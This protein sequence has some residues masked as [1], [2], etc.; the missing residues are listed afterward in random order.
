MESSRWHNP[1]PGSHIVANDSAVKE[2]DTPEDFPSPQAE[3]HAMAAKAYPGTGCH[4]VDPIDLT[5]PDQPEGTA[6]LHPYYPALA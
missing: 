3:R 1:S 6:N 5:S 2:E 4:S